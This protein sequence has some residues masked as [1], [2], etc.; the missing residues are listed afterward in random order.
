MIIAVDDPKAADVLALLEEHLDDMYATSPAES[1]HALDPEA[2]AHPSITFWTA[3]DAET[4]ELLGIGALKQHPDG[5]GELKSMRTAAAA[6]GRGVASAVLGA[7]LAE[8]RG[9]GIRDLKLETGTED[10]FAP[11]RALYA[12][13]GFLR[14]GPFADYT[15]DPNS[16]YFA[17]AL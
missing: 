15:D 10:Y 16:A 3:R 17:L 6:R 8:A 5:L 11:A 12:K 1:V 14:C 13:H 2:L 4:G 9:R 7:I